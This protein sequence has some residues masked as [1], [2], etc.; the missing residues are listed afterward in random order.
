MDSLNKLEVQTHEIRFTTDRERWRAQ[1]GVFFSESELIEVNDFT[2][3][4]SVHADGWGAMK[5]FA[6]NYPLTNTSVTGG[7]RECRRRVL[8]LPGAV[9]RRHHLPQ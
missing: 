4:S 7:G 9:R 3:P 1:G 5:G 8:H 2:Y 6:P